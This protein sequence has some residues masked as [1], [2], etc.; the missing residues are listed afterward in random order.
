MFSGFK[1][2]T[3]NNF[4]FNTD[5]FKKLNSEMNLHDLQK[6]NCDVETVERHFNLILITQIN[7]CI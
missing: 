5:N 2:F 6:F 7:E 1:Y 4:D 3:K